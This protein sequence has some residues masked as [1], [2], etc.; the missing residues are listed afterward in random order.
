MSHDQNTVT[1]PTRKTQLQILYH[2]LNEL[3]LELSTKSI[4]FNATFTDLN[5]GRERTRTIST[6]RPLNVELDMKLL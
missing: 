2:I 3:L 5:H 1:G 4:Y 6:K